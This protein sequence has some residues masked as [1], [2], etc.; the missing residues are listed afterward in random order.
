[1][2]VLKNELRIGNLVDLGD[3]IA[4]IIEINHLTCLVSDLEE[5]QDT[6]EDYERVKPILLNLDWCEKFNMKFEPN[7]SDN[8]YI[9]YL[10]NKEHDL[11]LQYDCRT[12]QFSVFESVNFGDGH[13][14]KYLRHVHELQNLYFALTDEELNYKKI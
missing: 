11:Y 6:I 14:L 8:D 2:E 3:R 5:T 9:T 4:K 13:I 1:M 7:F 12:S 10:I